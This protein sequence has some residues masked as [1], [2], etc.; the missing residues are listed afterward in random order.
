MQARKM[1][2]LDNKSTNKWAFLHMKLKKIAPYKRLSSSLLSSQTKITKRLIILKTFFSLKTTLFF[3]EQF[4]T[5]TSSTCLLA[6]DTSRSSLRT[7]AWLLSYERFHE[8]NNYMSVLHAKIDVEAVMNK[9][10][11]V[12]EWQKKDKKK[13][14][15]AEIMF[16]L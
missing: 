16:I 3:R 11:S 9:E 1:E 7:S 2:H 12:N 6:M 14:K 5:S 4:S 15:L 13:S 10:I 8:H